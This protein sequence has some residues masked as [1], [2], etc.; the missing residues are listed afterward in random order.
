M[1]IFEMMQTIGSSEVSNNTKLSESGLELYNGI[2]ESMESNIGTVNFDVLSGIQESATDLTNDQIKEFCNFTDALTNIYEDISIELEAA[3][4]PSSLDISSKLGK[5]K[6]AF[7]A[8]TKSAKKNIKAKNY[9][10]AKKNIKEAKS[11]LKE[12]ETMINQFDKHDL[13][14]NIIGHFIGGVVYLINNLVTLALPFIP[15]V[16]GIAAMVKSLKDSIGNLKSAIKDIKSDGLTLSVAN[17]ALH[18][19]ET[20]LRRMSRTLDAMEKNVDKLSSVKESSTIE[21]SFN[22]DVDNTDLFGFPVM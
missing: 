16:G 5:T 11:A 20:E 9:T 19:C 3:N 1:N 4:D 21:E 6:K 12:F 14:E 2:L 13:K 8:A 7:K 10:E 22:I 17:G 15:V 18:V